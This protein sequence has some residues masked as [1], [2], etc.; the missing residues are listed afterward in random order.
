M[1]SIQKNIRRGARS[2][3]TLIELLLVMVIISILAAIVVPK[4]VGRREQAN[5]TKAKADVSSLNTV[6][7]EFEVDNGRFPTQSEGLQALV[8]NP[9]NLPEWK[10]LLKEVPTDPWGRPYVYHCPGA[11]G[12]EYDVYSTGNSG[13]DG[14]AD[15]VK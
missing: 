2:G 10:S 11:N 6:L 8:T 14:N 3:F 12:Q 1:N 9:G 15:N 5:I 4:L 13:Q 7:Q